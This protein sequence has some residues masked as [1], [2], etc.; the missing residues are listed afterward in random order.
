MP[1]AL[2]LT[3]GMLTFLSAQ[4]LRP[5]IPLYAVDLGL[6]PALVGVALGMNGLVPALAGLHLGRLGQTIGFHRLIRWAGAAGLAAGGLYL[7]TRSYGGLVAAQAVSGLAFLGTWVGAQSYLTLLGGGPGRDRAVGLFTFTTGLGLAAGPYLGAAAFERWGYGGAYA[8]YLASAAL[9]VGC[10]AALGP[11]GGMRRGAAGEAAAAGPA[12]QVTALG[13]LRQPGIQL[14]AAVSTL[15][16]TVIGARNTFY[17][18]LLRDAGLA[19]ATIGALMSLAGA[20]TLAIRPFTR[21]VVARLGLAGSVLAA[22]VVAA[23]SLGLVP[24]VASVPLLAVLAAA[25]GLAT[26]LHQPLGITLVAEGSPPEAR[27]VAIGLRSTLNNL[28]AAGSPVVVGLLS[29]ALGL[30]GAFYAL[31]LALLALAALPVRL[32]RRVA[33]AA[34]PEGAAR[35]GLRG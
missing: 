24:L 19:P 33:G 28:A 21:D 30:A 12:R 1:L 7:G 14:A 34:R 26:G 10:G 31:A 13:L 29:G 9:L 27:G 11:P 5:V 4:L 2:V 18:I 6:S 8:A 35:P 17:P 32:A 22:L 16:L 20:S 23:A 3:I 15:S 25:N